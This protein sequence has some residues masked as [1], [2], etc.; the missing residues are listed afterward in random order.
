[1]IT[2]F[3]R[4]EELRHIREITGKRNQMFSVTANPVFKIQRRYKLK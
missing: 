3:E 4:D 2:N 1:M